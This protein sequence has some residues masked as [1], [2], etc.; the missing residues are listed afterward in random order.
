MLPNLLYKDVFLTD[1]RMHV[2]STEDRT[3]ASKLDVQ[4][5]ALNRNTTHS[6]YIFP[7]AATL[8]LQMMVMK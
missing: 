6:D 4:Y 2:H 5:Q 3:L 8:T 7:D 1:R